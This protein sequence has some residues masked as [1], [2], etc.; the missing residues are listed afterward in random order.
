MSLNDPELARGCTAPLIPAMDPGRILIRI[1]GNGNLKIPLDK[2]IVT[3]GRR[4]TNDICLRSRFI[5]R[6]HARIINTAEGAYIED[7]SSRNGIRVNNIRVR[8]HKLHSGDLI[9]LGSIQLRYLDLRED[10]ARG[11]NA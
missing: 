9:D 10:D 2:T 11:G 7:I 8:Q 3:V 5:S 6:Y 4:S 1:T